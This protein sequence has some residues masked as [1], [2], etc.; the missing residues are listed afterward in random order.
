MLECDVGYEGD[1]ASC[2]GLQSAKERK[3]RE[4]ARC[5]GEARRRVVS[6]V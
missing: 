6:V 1:G 2:D 4:G 5:D 3:G